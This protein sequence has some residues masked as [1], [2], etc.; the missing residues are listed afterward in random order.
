MDSQRLLPVLITLGIG[1][2]TA[3]LLQFL[4][5]VLSQIGILVVTLLLAWI[6]TVTALGP[7]R[8]LRRLHMPRWIAAP[9]VYLLF[10]GLV[11]L[12]AF[13]VLPPFFAQTGVAAAQITDLASEIPDALANLEQQLVRFGVPP[14]FVEELLTGS[15]AQVVTL[16]Q[17][18]AN[19]VLATTGAVLG[20]LALALLTLIISFY[21]LVGWDRNVRGMRQALPTGW[22]ARFDRGVRA[23]ERTFGGWLGGQFVASTIWGAAVVVTY[24][25][26]GMDFGLLVAVG[27]GL[28]MFVPFFGLTVGIVLPTI[29]ALTIRIDLVIWVGIT[30]GATSLVVENVIKPRVMGTAIGVNPLVVILSVLL[31]AVAAGFWGILFGIPIGALAWTFVKWGA[32]ELLH[33]QQRDSGHPSAH[34]DGDAALVPA[35]PMAETT[36]D[37]QS[38]PDSASS[39]GTR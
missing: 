6:I 27:T 19:N 4:W 33:A 17:D 34:A 30:L 18:I 32:G 10:A 28:L 39:Q 2:A 14:N 3:W 26:A 24:F 16:A 29:M 37:A 15:S 12:A 22:R 8:L 20:G 36:A 31:G 23:A 5:D 25:V 38:A 11:A 35:T 21:L 7:V 1:V 13:F 9:L